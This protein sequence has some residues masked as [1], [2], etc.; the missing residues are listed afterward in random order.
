MTDYHH[1]KHAYCTLISLS[2]CYLN[3]TWL[4]QRVCYISQMHLVLKLNPSTGPH[5]DCRHKLAIQFPV[6]SK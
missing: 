3:T 5:L 1:T 4:S 2:Y 6:S